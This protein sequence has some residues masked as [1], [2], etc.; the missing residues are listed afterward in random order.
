MAVPCRPAC[1]IPF[2]DPRSAVAC[3]HIIYT[4]TLYLRLFIRVKRLFYFL[5]SPFPPSSFSDSKTG[6]A[7]T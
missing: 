6:E 3:V 1:L 7:L 4:C 2:T 5:G